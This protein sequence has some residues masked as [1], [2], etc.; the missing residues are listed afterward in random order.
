MQSRS[1]FPPW[2]GYAASALIIAVGFAVAAQRHQFSRPSPAAALLALVVAPWIVFCDSAVNDHP[3]VRNTLQRWPL[4]DTLVFS[5]IVIGGT[6]GLV[7][8]YP[9][10]D[11][12]APFFMVMLAGT[13]AAM[14]GPWYGIGAAAASAASLVGLDAAGVF[15]GSFIWAFAIAVAWLTGAALRKQETVLAQLAAA[16]ADLATRAAAEERGRL[17]REIHDLIAHSLA[18]T[19]L[20]LTGARLALKDGDST[21]AIDAL[22]QAE[23]TG[24]LA[25][26][27]IRRTVG[28]LDDTGTGSGIQPTPKAADVPEL[29]AAFSDAGLD[30]DSEIDGD[31]DLVPLAVGVALYR[32]VQESL[33]NAVKHAPGQPVRLRV[34]ADGAS[35][36]AT[37][38]NPLSAS[39]GPERPRPGAP[40]D[41]TEGGNGLRGM[42]ER[43]QLLGGTVQAGPRG[44]SWVVEACLPLDTPAPG[45]EATA[46]GP[47]VADVPR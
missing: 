33:S 17:A 25:M 15:T 44:G 13:I 47:H 11:D 1:M 7:R 22:G 24:R 14:V 27:E 35:L 41:A 21:E 37:V 30:A 3:L 29:V 34:R 43:A 45:S 6:L 2:S 10:N 20:H 40:A 16:Q 8:G 39:L 36:R 18:V 42:G 28:L 12:F 31:L 4:V 5:A 19:M 38:I 32:I 9:V 23:E 46:Y 26:S